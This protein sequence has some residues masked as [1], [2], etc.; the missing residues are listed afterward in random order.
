MQMKEG[1]TGEKK[2]YPIM[3]SYSE[4]MAFAGILRYPKQQELLKAELKKYEA[5]EAYIEKLKG[6]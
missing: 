2:E 4:E 1:L 5:V 6:C 3:N